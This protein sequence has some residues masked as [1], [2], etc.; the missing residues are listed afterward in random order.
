MPLLLLERTDR[1][2]HD[3]WGLTERKLMEYFK[4]LEME[5]FSSSSSIVVVVDEV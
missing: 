5:L 2:A 4:G 1:E 3:S